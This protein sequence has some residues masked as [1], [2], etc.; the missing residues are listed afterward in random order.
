M[1]AWI[2]K[3]CGKENDYW[4]ADNI[5]IV[6][7]MYMIYDYASHSYKFED[8]ICEYCKTKKSYDKGVLLT[9]VKECPNC[10]HKFEIEDFKEEVYKADEDIE[11][12]IG[13]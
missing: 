5:T 4:R 13:D 1:T 7:D 12:K 9:I 2:C 10:G 8:I 6:S 11:D 3:N